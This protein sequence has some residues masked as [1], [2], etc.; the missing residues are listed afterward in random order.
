[1]KNVF[2]TEDGC[3]MALCE[4]Q[5]WVPSDPRSTRVYLL[6]NEQELGGKAKDGLRVFWPGETQQELLGRVEA[7]TEH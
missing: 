3:A 6:G 4:L 5:R 2:P 1:M 7:A